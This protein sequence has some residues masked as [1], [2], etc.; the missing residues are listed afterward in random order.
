MYSLHLFFRVFI[1]LDAMAYVQEQ[2]H[3]LSCYININMVNIHAVFLHVFIFYLIFLCLGAF[4]IKL[5]IILLTPVGYKKIISY[6][7][8]V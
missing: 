4:N 3:C 6:P 8:H 2:F 7:T 1:G 5:V